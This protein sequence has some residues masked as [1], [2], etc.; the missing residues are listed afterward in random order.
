M[1]N[2]DIIFFATMA[3]ALLILIPA[4]FWNQYQDWMTYWWWIVLTP[5]A[6]A[7]AFFPN[8]KFVNWLEHVSKKN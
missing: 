5:I 6:L 3:L 4:A 8:S 1:R 7:K 2:S